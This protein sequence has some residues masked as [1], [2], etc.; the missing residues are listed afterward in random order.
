MIALSN[1]NKPLWKKEGI[2]KGDLIEYYSKVA[3]KLIPFMVD[4]PAWVQRFP[5]GIPGKG[6]VQKDWPVHA[7]WMKT[8][9]VPSHDKAARH[10]VIED[11]ATLVYL[12]DMACM[13]IN[14]LLSK[15]PKIDD[16]DLVLVDLDPHP[17]GVEF[18][19]V[20]AVAE[21]VRVALKQMKLHFIMKT[22]GSEGMHFLIPIVPKYGP[23]TIKKFVLQLGIVLEELS[24]KKVTTSRHRSERLGKI[25]VDYDQ[26][27]RNS[28]VTPFSPRPTAGAPVSYP[29]S[30]KD[31][32]KRF[33]PVD[34]N[35]RTV[36][37]FA[38]EEKLPELDY[39]PGQT[40]ESALKEL[41]VA[42]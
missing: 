2:T 29:L 39:V 22:S 37:Q 10:V 20:L 3:S 38:D 34:F 15:P 6:F 28:I 21:N 19:D 25:F 27:T 17:P 30:E 8:M 31:L 9:P 7:P 13:E 36:S 14:N 1:L 42:T 35:V 32:K 23:E 16:H 33:E 24:P 26:N 40:L 4:R 41:G 12:G 5:H 18:E 11:R